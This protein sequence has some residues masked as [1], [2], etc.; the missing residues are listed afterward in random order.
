M[1]DELALAT[2]EDDLIVSAKTP[3][4]AYPTDVPAEGAEDPN[5][6]PEPELDEGP[7]VTA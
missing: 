4:T 5:Y 2:S 1:S 3:E 7:E 6:E